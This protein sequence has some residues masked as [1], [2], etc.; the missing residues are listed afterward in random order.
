MFTWQSSSFNSKRFTS[1]CASGEIP[2]AL[3][4]ILLW[5]N[6]S[7]S[8][9]DISPVFT[10]SLTNEWSTVICVNRFWLGNQLMVIA[11]GIGGNRSGDIAAEQTVATLGSQFKPSESKSLGNIVKVGE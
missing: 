6:F 8:S 11:D 4:I 2:I 1:T 5:G 10:N 7:A 3:V 9:S